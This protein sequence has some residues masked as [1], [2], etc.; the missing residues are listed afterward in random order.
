MPNTSANNCF[1]FSS[2]VCISISGFLEICDYPGRSGG[3]RLIE[4]ELPLLGVAI[5]P[6][7]PESVSRV[8]TRNYAILRSP[9]IQTDHSSAS[10]FSCCFQAADQKTILG[11]TPDRPATEEKTID[12]CISIAVLHQRRSD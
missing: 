12:H 6:H 5:L 4:R 3:D 9:R 7:H 8:E 1:S 10:P 11:A 2:L